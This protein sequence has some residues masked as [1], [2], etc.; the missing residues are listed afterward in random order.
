MEEADR[1]E[2]VDASS[3]RALVKPP[4]LHSCATQAEVSLSKHAVFFKD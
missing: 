1:G 4:V 3:I 2:R